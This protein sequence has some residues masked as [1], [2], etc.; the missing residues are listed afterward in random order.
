VTASASPLNPRRLREFR[1]SLAPDL[2]LPS[3]FVPWSQIEKDLRALKPAAIVVQELSNG[4]RIS[5]S[6]LERALRSEPGVMKVFQRLLA[7]PGGVGFADGR[8][9]P[10]MPPTSVRDARDVAALLLELGI[11]NIL[12][13]NSNVDD[14]LRVA[15]IGADARKRGYRRSGTIQSRVWSALTKAIDETSDRLGVK[16]ELSRLRED[17]PG[18]R[19]VQRRW[20]LAAAETPIAAVVPVIQTSTGGRQQR[21]LSL[22]YPTLQAELDRVPMALILIADGRGIADSPDRVLNLLFES[23]AACMSVKDAESGALAN[24]IEVSAINRGV[25]SSAL[26][27]VTHL[28]DNR[29]RDAPSVSLRDLPVGPDRGALALAQY[30]STHGDLALTLSPS[31]QQLSW[32]F[33]DRVAEAHALARAFR[34]ARALSVLAQFLGVGKSLPIALE[35]EKRAGVVA[36]VFTMPIDVILPEKMLAVASPT[37]PTNDFLRA[38]AKTALHRTPDARIALVTAPPDP[39]S[40]LS[41]PRKV[42]ARLSTS[43]VQLQPAHLVRMA[44]STRPARD[45]LVELVLQ[46]ADLTKVSPY[47]LNSATPQRIFYGREEEEAILLS[48]LPTNSVAILGGR[49]IGKTSLLQHVHARLEDADFSALFGDCQTVRQWADFGSMARRKWGARLPKS[50][51]PEHLFDLARQLTQPA[52]QL[53]FL[54]DEIDQLLDWDQRHTDDE[55]SEAFFRACRTLSQE[56]LAQFVFTGERTIAMKL[57]DAHSPHW[58]FCRPLP[59]QQLTRIAA[60]ELLE[61]PMESLGIT[62]EDRIEFESALWRYTSGHPQLVQYLGDRLV[63][64]LNERRPDRRGILNLEDLTR[65]AEA[66]EYREHY[67]E[68]YWGQATTLERLITTMGTNGRATTVAALRDSIGLLGVE[69][70]EKE[71]TDGLRMLELYGVISQGREGYERRAEWLDRA[72]S[73]YGGQEAAAARFVR[74]MRG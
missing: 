58:N 46:Q 20:I 32:Q 74:E 41:D 22:T 24:A 15:L 47:V 13:R 68:T 54:M 51:R 1:D 64:L 42:Q 6:A 49:R 37:S 67:L 36:R 38:V 26:A 35:G 34:P 31:G 70:G 18:L 65:V 40:G 7:A 43:V 60:A 21:D 63:R 56:G 66:Y 48:T 2:Y 17:I 45:T 55:V 61:R 27:G 14:L 28:I 71:I 59:L 50:F 10:E 62:I 4:P 53:V 12:S 11:T 8:E 9:I 5:R 25:R 23:V 57:W 16:V 73:A 69:A 39:L 30:A 3:D 72:L 19:S 52:R 29:L 44:E 33:P